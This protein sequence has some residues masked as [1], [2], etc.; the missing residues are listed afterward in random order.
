MN[1]NGSE[2]LRPE[3]FHSIFPLVSYILAKGFFQ[4]KHLEDLCIATVWRPKSQ[5]PSIAE[6]QLSVAERTERR[7]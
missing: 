7:A 5:Q 6:S 1:V 4:R 3:I 2:S